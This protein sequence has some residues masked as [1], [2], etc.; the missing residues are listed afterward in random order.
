WR[1]DPGAAEITLDHALA[2]AEE[3]RLR[4]GGLVHGVALAGCSD[5]DRAFLEAMAE[6]D[7][8]SATRVI[9]ERLQVTRAYAN[10]YRT[11]LLEAQLIEVAGR[12]RVDFAI[13]YLREYVRER[14][15]AE[16]AR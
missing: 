9:A 15:S 5:V 8:P 1:Q 16:N 10:V 6:D 3:A 12:G 11:R 14:A 7:G 2:G 4:L 13:P